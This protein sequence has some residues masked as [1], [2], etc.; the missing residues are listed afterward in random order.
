MNVKDLKILLEKLPEDTEIS[1]SR[2]LGDQFSDQN[3][4]GGWTL[5]YGMEK[6]TLIL[7]PY[8]PKIRGDK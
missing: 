8:D 2:P 4:V 5:S 7:W 3:K 6:P 1:I